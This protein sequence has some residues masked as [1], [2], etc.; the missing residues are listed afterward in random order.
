[1]T[2]RPNF[3]D[4]FDAIVVGAGLAGSAAALTMAQQDLEV[5]LIERGNYPGAKNVFGGTMYTPRIRELTGEGFEDAPVE[6]H[7]GTK[8]FGLL[9]TED[10]TAMSIKPGQWQESPHNDTYTVLR[11]NFDEWFADQAIEAGATLITETT[12]TD[13]VREGES[14]VGVETDRPDGTIHAPMVVLA[15]GGNSLVSEAADLKETDP[16][17]KVAIGVK[18]VR[19]YDRETIEERFGLGEDDGAAYHYFGEGACGGGVGGGF[20]Y[21]NKRTLAIGV[22]YTISDAI[23]DDRKPDELLSDFKEHPAVAPLVKGGRVVEYSAKSIPE[24]GASSVPELAHDGAVI[25]GDAASLLLNNGIHLEGT[26]MAVESGYL[27]GNAIVEAIHAGRT[28]AA[29][30]QSYPEELESSYVME[31][32]QNYDWF[33]DFAHDEKQFLFQQLPKAL[34][35]AELEFFKQDYEPKETHAKRAKN[36]LLRAAGGWTGAAKK[37]WKY[38][39]LLS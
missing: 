2:E 13:L 11:G 4:Y 5:L 31:N 24:G 35:E 12:V 17:E 25:I 29:A 34:T 33:S 27:A 1:M 10:E 16:P 32:L 23:E 21:T 7:L 26:N 20:I 22:A 37:A 9:S 6:R 38:R 28:D 39:K 19:K 36:M 18:E 30:L 15:E 3:D 14:I 8:R